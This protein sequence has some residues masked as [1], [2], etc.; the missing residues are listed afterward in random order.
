[1]KRFLSLAIA[2]LVGTVATAGQDD[3]PRFG[4]SVEVVAVDANVVDTN[5]KPVRDL[6]AADFQVKVDGKRRNVVS[7]DFVQL[8]TVQSAV[9]PPSSDAPTAA[10][11]SAGLRRPT[12][13]GR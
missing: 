2:F 3:P 1:M 5:G 8:V 9:A 13:E 7:A 4:G 10:A 12:S 6:T 11:P